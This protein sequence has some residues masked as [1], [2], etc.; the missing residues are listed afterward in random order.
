MALIFS[1][2]VILQPIIMYTKFSVHRIKGPLLIEAQICLV[3]D[4]LKKANPAVPENFISYSR[5]LRYPLP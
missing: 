4:V 5:T 1:D 2:W 3:G